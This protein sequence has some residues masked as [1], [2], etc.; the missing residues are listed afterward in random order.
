MIDNHP[1]T[2][3]NTVVICDNCSVHDFEEYIHLSFHKIIVIYLPPNSTSKYQPCD[4]QLFWSLKRKYR[5]RL[6]ESYTTAI[7]Q[8]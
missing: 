1:N 2:R 5:N 7:P 6:I 4:Q 8:K 3:N